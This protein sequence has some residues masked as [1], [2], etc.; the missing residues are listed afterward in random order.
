MYA[1]TG[2]AVSFL[3]STAWALSISLAAQLSGDNQESVQYAGILG[4]V[5]VLALGL[6][7]LVP[8][9]DPKRARERVMAT[10]GVARR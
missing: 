6:L 7:V 5:V 10:D 8:I 4:I 2:R 3:S 9:K 1:T